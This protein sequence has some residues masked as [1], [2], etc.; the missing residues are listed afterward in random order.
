MAPRKKAEAPESGPIRFS[1][2]YN[3]V[4]G[5]V[6]TAYKAGM[7]VREPSAELREAAIAKG[8]AEPFVEEPG[9]PG[10]E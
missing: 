5:L 6:T 9:E 1:A 4:D 2:G 7:V 8:K 10:G 3:H